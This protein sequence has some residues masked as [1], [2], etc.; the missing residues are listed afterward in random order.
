MDFVILYRN[1]QNKKIGF[2]SEEDPDKIA[3]FKSFEDAIDGARNTT[4]CRAFPYQVI[5]VDEI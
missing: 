5:A 4:I 3:V 2:V 1:T